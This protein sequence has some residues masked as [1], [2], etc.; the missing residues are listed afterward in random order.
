MSLQYSDALANFLLANGSVKD[1]IDGGKI[2]I[3]TGAQPANANAAKTGTLLVTITKSSG[4]ITAEVSA[5]GS[6]RFAG[7]AGSIDT[8]TVDGYD[9]L[10]GSVPFNTTLAQTVADAAYNINVNPKNKVWVATTD[11]ID[12]ITITEQNGLGTYF[13]GK[14]LTSTQTTMTQGTVV[15]PTGG[16][17]N[18]NG[19]HFGVPAAQVLGKHTAETWSGVAVADGVAGWFRFYA[20]MTDSGALD[21][22]A[23]FKRLDGNIATSG[24]TMNMS[25]TTIVTSAVQTITAVALTQ[26]ES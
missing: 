24:A 23:V 15:N 9:I 20:S 17:D 16:V 26:P 13:N 21:S 5:V 3:Y 4:A 11:A 18:I 8:I 14:T 19:L 10:G 1:A 25:N 2:E 12:K 7:A 6:I 22:S